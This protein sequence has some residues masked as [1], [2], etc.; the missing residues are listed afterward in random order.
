MGNAFIH[1]IDPILVRLGPVHISYYAL[2]FAVM[3]CVGYLVWRHQMV[4]GGYPEELAEKF[5]TWGIIGGFAGMRLGHC[6]FYY[7]EHYFSD[8]LSILY[9]WRGGLSSHGASVGL[10]AAL[11]LFTRKYRL[12][13][14]DIFDR[15]SLTAAVFAIFVRMGNFF[16]SEIVGRATDLP[17]AVRFIRFDGGMTARHPSQIYEAALGLFILFALYATDKKAG[18]EE[19]PAGLLI[20]L[21]T[22]LYFGGRFLIEFVKEYHVLDPAIHVTMGQ[23]LSIPPFIAGVVI[24]VF[25]KLGIFTK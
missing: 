9:I 6:F 7:P 21:F 2:I 22:V 23:Y 8:P 15:F 18:Q 25:I 24:L 17:W 19:R 1:N 16:N 3:L 11:I 13:V 20:G 14:I 10:M 5:F 4:R 12:N